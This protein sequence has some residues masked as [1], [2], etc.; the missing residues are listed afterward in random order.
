MR[1]ISMAS[2]IVVP[3]SIQSTEE[4]RVEIG[5]CAGQAARTAL[6][7]SSGKR[8][9]FSSEPP[10]SSVRRLVSGEMNDDIR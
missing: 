10:Y 7:T 3:P 1:P 6:N 2:S 9:R 5:L 4:M 8:M